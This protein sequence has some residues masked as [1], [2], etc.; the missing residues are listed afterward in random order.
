L[1]RTDKTLRYMA[2]KMA[3]PNQGSIRTMYETLVKKLGAPHLMN[4]HLN[5]DP[6]AAAW[7]F[8]LDDTHFCILRYG[9]KLPYDVSDWMVCANSQAEYNEV[10][11]FFGL[12]AE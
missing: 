1:T 8:T 12:E 10:R 2:S 9:K 6:Y 5:D 7:W 11:E 3:M 4:G